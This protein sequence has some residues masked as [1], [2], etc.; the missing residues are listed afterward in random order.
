MASLLRRLP[1]RSMCLIVVAAL[2]VTAGAAAGYAPADGTLGGTGF[3]CLH[4]LGPQSHD[5]RPSGVFAARRGLPTPETIPAL[6]PRDP[7]ND[8]APRSRPRRCGALAEHSSV[9]GHDLRGRLD[10]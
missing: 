6:L 5:G 1:A 2:S 7:G 9:H 3:G 8:R 4:P 10:L